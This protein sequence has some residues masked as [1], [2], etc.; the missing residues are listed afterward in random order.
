MAVS[1]Q[2]LSKHVPAETNMHT[3]I[4]EQ[5]FLCGQHKGVKED[6]WCSPVQLMVGSSVQLCKG[7]CKE[8]AL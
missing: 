5:R 4:E 2:Q 6:N 1:E 3:T 8:I 7:G